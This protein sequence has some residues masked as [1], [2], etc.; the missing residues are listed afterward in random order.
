MQRTLIFSMSA[1]T[2]SRAVIKLFIVLII[3]SNLIFSSHSCAL[4]YTLVNIRFKTC[5]SVALLDFCN[6]I[7]QGRFLFF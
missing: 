2:V 1:A 5:L 6:L 4:Y 3:P 7:L